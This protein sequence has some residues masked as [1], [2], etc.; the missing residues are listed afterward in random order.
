MPRG[1]ADDG[2]LVRDAQDRCAAGAGSAPLG[3]ARAIYEPQHYPQAGE[4]NPEVRL[5]VGAFILLVALV[6]AGVDILE[7]SFLLIVVGLRTR[8]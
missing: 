1:A 2:P 3:G 6:I 4:N 7:T 8:R 5:G